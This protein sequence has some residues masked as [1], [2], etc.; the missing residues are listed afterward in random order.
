[1]RRFGLFM[2][3]LLA[4]VVAATPA[5]HAGDGASELCFNGTGGTEVPLMPAPVTLGLEF[6]AD[7]THGIGVH[8]CYSTSPVGYAGSELTGGMVRF[9]VAPN[10]SGYVLCARDNNPATATVTCGAPFTVAP[11]TGASTVWFAGTVDTTATS[12]VNVGQTGIDGYDPL[13]VLVPCTKALG[14]T[15]TGGC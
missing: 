6:S 13:V 2:G 5:A 10:G 12:P 3:A 15:V 4:V 9:H 8:V 11:L 7:P 1:M 14:L